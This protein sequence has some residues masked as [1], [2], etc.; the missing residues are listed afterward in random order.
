MRRARLPRFPFRASCPAAYEQRA[1]A[2]ERRD[3][4]SHQGDIGVPVGRIDAAPRRSRAGRRER[5]VDGRGLHGRVVAA[6]GRE[7]GL[8]AGASGS[9]AGGE[10]EILHARGDRGEGGGRMMV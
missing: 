3:K 2:G 6:L 7:V 5:G 10:G 4:A 9:R 8:Q 1:G